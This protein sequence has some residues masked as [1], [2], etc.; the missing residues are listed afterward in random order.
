MKT[1]NLKKIGVMLLATMTLAST[2]FGCGKAGDKETIGAQSKEKGRYVEKEMTLP[3]GV[4]AE[5]IF[6]IEK[7]DDKLCI[8]VKKLQEKQL[9][10]SQFTYDGNAS[11]SETTKEWLKNFSFHDNGYLQPQIVEGSKGT[12]YLYVTYAES[13]EEEQK[14]HLYKTT[15][16]ENVEDITPADWLVEDPEYHYF[17]SPME[18][19]LLEDGT[20]VAQFY[21]KTVMYQGE[22]GTLLATSDLYRPYKEHVYADGNQYLLLGKNDMDYLTGID[23]F[24]SGKFD[25]VKQYPYE[26]LISGNSYSS[27]IDIIEDHSIVLANEDGF[28]KLT[29]GDDEWKQIIQAGFT[30]LSMQNMWCSDMVAMEDEKFYALFGDSNG[31]G[32]LMEYIYDPD[33]AVAADKELTV[34]T[35]Y[36][37]PTLEQAAAL[38]RKS[39]PD[40]MVTVETVLSYEDQYGE[41]DMDSIYQ[42]LNGKLIAKE[43]ADVLA[44]DGLN[45]RSFTEKG[46]LE[47]VSDVVTP[48]MESGEILSNVVEPYKEDGKIYVVPGRFSMT[49][50]I[51]KDTKADAVA[52]LKSLANAAANSQVSL[53]GEM[54]VEDLLDQ[55]APFVIPKVIDGKELNAEALKEN[56]EY[57]KMIADNSG[58]VEEYGENGRGWGLW[59]VASNVDLALQADEGFA[60]AMF[61]L[62]VAK[63]VNGSFTSFDNAYTPMLELGI[64]SSSNQ[65]E[66]AKEFLKFVMSSE[67]QDSDFYDGYPINVASL[68]TQ[69]EMDRTNYEAYTEIELA[70][71]QHQEFVIGKFDE[72]AGEKLVTLCKGLTN[73][74]A[75]DGVVKTAILE[76]LPD[77]LNGSASVEQT[78][79]KIEGILKMYLAE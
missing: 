3:E 31:G 32:A 17:D 27:I 58:I 75:E 52:D 25:A 2:L 72:Q 11:W 18:I 60:Q 12:D 64:N 9:T 66:L 36:E 34:Y 65:K 29:P 14:G 5:N 59:N 51:G 7:V 45:I 57:L 10:I 6:Q 49:L 44:M 61:P 68:N 53:M 8:Y 77:Y 42:Q 20:I 28:F 24:E 78:V 15:D 35:V 41:V 55:F 46:L 50:L 62:S 70:D 40:V 74:T 26:E 22:D 38:F 1:T 67:V 39:H 63:L 56:L 47:D 37:S 79:E 19:A 23:A 21:S 76:A 54:T 16:G 30:S 69:K 13:E 48:M 4:S 71:G 73:R 43:A 33:M